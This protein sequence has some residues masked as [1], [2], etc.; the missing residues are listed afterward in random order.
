MPIISGGA[1]AASGGVYTSISTQAPSGAAS[2]TF[3]GLSP[4]LYTWFVLEWNLNTSNAADQHLV[5]QVNGDTT[6]GHY[7]WMTLDKITSEQNASDSSAVLGWI[8]ASSQGAGGGGRVF[9]PAQNGGNTRNGTGYYGGN[10]TT[11]ART[12]TS[13]QGYAFN[14]AANVTSIVI[15]AAAGNLSGHVNLYGS[16]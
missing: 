7:Y 9:I 14:I 1:G 2:V 10:G 6:A 11:G 5:C 3:S 13:L 15:F 12:G 16:P 8:P 4:L